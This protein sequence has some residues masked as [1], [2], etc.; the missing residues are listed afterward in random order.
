MQPIIEAWL[1]TL[2]ELEKI[3]QLGESAVDAWWESLTPEQRRVFSLLI[4]HGYYHH[5][6][7]KSFTERHLTAQQTVPTSAPATQ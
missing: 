2:L 7:T 1:T 5:L 6:H 4:Q 3:K